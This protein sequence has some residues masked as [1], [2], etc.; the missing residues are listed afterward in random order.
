MSSTF[1]LRRHI[2]V[3]TFRAIHVP[4]LLAYLG[5]ALHG[6]FAGTDSPLPAV[7]AM[8]Q[9]TLLVIIFLACYWLVSLLLQRLAP[10][11]RR[12]R[13][14]GLASAFCL[15]QGIFARRAQNWY[16][17]GKGIEEIMEKRSER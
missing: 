5:A 14:H 1:Y 12:R 13:A 15:E 17:P 7:Q 16:H 4:G 10:A 2:E 3:R 11:P 6:L 8:Y 9:L